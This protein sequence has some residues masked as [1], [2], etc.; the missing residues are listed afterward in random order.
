MHEILMARGEGGFPSYAFKPH[1]SGHRRI[2]G[3]NGGVRRS[4]SDEVFVCD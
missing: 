4:A 1:E 3:N 2:R